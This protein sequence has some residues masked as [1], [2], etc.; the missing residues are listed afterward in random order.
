[1]ARDKGE[2][3]IT[4]EDRGPKGYFAVI[5]LADKPQPVTL[6]DVVTEILAAEA[7]LN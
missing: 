6:N 7:E 1:M 5:E 4:L 2:G 3:V